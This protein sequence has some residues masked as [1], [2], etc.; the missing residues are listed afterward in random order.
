LAIPL[1]IALMAVV[2][3]AD[4]VAKK[5][6]DLRVTAVSASAT[7]AA[8][9]TLDAS[10][11]T[12]NGGNR[13]APRST[14]G[15]LL[16]RDERRDRTD[17][18]L[19]GQRAVPKLKPRGKSGGRARLGVASST[20]AGRYRLLACAD[21]A[22]RIAE[23]N[24]SNNCKASAGFVEIVSSG[25]GPTG[26]IPPATTSPMTTPPETTPPDTI[27]PEPFAGAAF[28]FTDLDLRDP[29]VVVDVVPIGAF[30]IT[31]SGLLG[32]SINGQLQKSLT[33]DESGDGFFDLSPVNLFDPFDQGAATMPAQIDPGATCTAPPQPVACEPGSPIATTAT[34]SSAGSCLDVIDGTTTA[35]Y[36]PEVAIP[37]APCFVTDEGDVTLSLAG[38]PMTLHAA[39]VAATYVGDPAT[40]EENGLIRGF[41][42]E[43]DANATVIPANLPVVG[44]QPL[45]KLFPGGTGNPSSHD[46]RDVREAV[47]GWWVYL[48]FTASRT[49]WV[50]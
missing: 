38:I 46:D 36:T 3:P 22:G 42:S 26:P 31:D 30:D 39:R 12:G 7:S 43:A 40:G 6:P 49:P 23:A 15:F 32:N 2:S 14:T 34:N 41:I 20:P 25:T 50:P 8:G 19:E 18:V 47:T 21:I 29:H 17:L 4:S 28:R 27:P 45:S 11:S 37:T 48:N 1:S 5:K 24:E 16:S 13:P 33:T 10:D 9:A 35:S 44:G